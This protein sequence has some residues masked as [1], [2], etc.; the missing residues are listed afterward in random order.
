[1]VL[2]FFWTPRR[3]TDAFVCFCLLSTVAG[4][5]LKAPLRNEHISRYVP[6]VVLEVLMVSPLTKGQYDDDYDDDRFH[7][8]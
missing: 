5:H 7:G 8:D 2:S 6:G 1:M 4:E 3:V